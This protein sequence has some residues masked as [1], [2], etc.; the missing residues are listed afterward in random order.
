MN[1]ICKNSFI[2]LLMALMAVSCTSSNSELEKQP[3]VVTG[4]VK[5]YDKQDLTVSYRA[6][7]VLSK[8][9]KK[10]IEINADGSFKFRIESKYPVR[11]FT[12]FGKVP[13]SYTYTI[14]LNNGKDTTMTTGSYDFRLVYFYLQPG[15]S[16]NMNVNV[17]D[18][19]STLSFSG[20]GAQ[21]NEFVNFENNKFQSYKN[22][23]LNNYHYIVSK[24][25]AEYKQVIDAKKKVQLD[26]LKQY[27]D[28]HE[29]SEHLVS[30]YKWNY[31]ADA[32]TSK[33]YYPTSRGNF[34]DKEVQ[35]PGK[36][37]T[38]VDDVKL[39]DK[40][41]DKGVG[42]FYF[43]SAY[44]KKKYESDAQENISYYDYIG[45][46]LD[47]KQAYVYYAYALSGDF[48]NELYS[49][50]G[51][52]SPFPQLAARVKEAYKDFEGM[53]PGT[54]AP[55]V[56]VVTLDENVVPLSKYKG[57]YVYIDLWA[58]WCGPC[59]EEIPSLKKLQKKY[60]GKNVQFISISIDEPKDKDKWKQFVTEH[61]LTGIQLWM[62]NENVE[63]LFSAFNIK[64][65]P[66]FIVLDPNGKVVDANAPRPSETK[67]IN[68][69][70][71]NL[72]TNNS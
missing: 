2:L 48:N 19:Q 56:N 18:I 9:E 29:L 23:Y 12:S 28:E 26:F 55:S 5:N 11:A 22:K 52:D 59:I 66:R 46:I 70:F 51:T 62:D 36:Y 17:E 24:E 54:P 65:I 41:T 30:V 60:K 34:L 32:F 53:L 72:L 21:N 61:N 8:L 35:L 16:L 13:T 57:E 25:P 42:Y 45:S 15:D 33:L 64:T 37:Y 7:D 3:I 31:I 14:T 39:S 63:K 20:N 27:N 6:Y 50:F 43:L 47:K 71:S 49:K 68:K 1:L 58:T 44:L 10:N 4:H 69:L 40:F 67:M 38:F